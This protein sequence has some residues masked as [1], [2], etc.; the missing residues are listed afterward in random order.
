MAADARQSVAGIAAS[1]KPRSPAVSPSRP[2]TGAAC[3]IAPWLALK[4]AGRGDGYDVPITAYA[5]ADQKTL[6]D[7]GVRRCCARSIR[8]ATTAIPDRSASSRSPSSPGRTPA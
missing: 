4:I 6:I 1:A 7:F 8:C 5:E 3:E 2:T